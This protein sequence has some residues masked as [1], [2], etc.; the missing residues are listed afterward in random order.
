[1]YMLE[2][3]YAFVQMYVEC[4]VIYPYTIHVIHFRY[5][6]HNTIYLFLC[7]MSLPGS[8]QCSVVCRSH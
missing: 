7:P 5:T 8:P 6:L 2:K 1:M 3:E 4:S